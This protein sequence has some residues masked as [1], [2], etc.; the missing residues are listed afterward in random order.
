MTKRQEGCLPTAFGL[1]L[2]SIAVT[3]ARFSFTL[4]GSAPLSQISVTIG[5]VKK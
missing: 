4:V 1:S 2:N 3:T 5:Y